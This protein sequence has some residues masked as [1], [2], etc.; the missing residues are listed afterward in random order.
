[1]RY[2]PDETDTEKKKMYFFKKGLNVRVRLG[3]SGHACKSLREMLN[4][5]IEIERDRMEADAIF[6]ERKRRAEGSSRAPASQ[7]SR[8]SASQPSR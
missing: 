8:G 1:M 7:R 4:K 3:L 6:K 5:S 2:A